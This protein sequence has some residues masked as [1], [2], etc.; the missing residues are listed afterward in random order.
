MEII[1][2]EGPKKNVAIIFVRIGKF[3]T[4]MSFVSAIGSLTDGSGL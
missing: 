1:A 4:L 3:Y 2:P